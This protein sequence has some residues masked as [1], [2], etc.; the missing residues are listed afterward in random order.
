MTY[1]GKGCDRIPHRARLRPRRRRVGEQR[2]NDGGG[3]SRYERKGTIEA[4]SGDSARRGG[5]EA[6]AVV[7]QM[8][9]ATLL[10][11]AV[12]GRGLALRWWV[13]GR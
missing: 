7:G 3:G 8:R 9:A 4:T 2:V 12:A 10:Q 11:R 6:R 5:M 1:I 13:C